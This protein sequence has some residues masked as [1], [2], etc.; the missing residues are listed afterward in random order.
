MGTR[1]C[2]RSIPP[3]AHPHSPSLS[4]HGF[5]RWVYD[6]GPCYHQPYENDAQARKPFKIKNSLCPDTRVRNAWRVAYASGVGDRASVG[7]R[8]AQGDGDAARGSGGVVG[9]LARARCSAIPSDAGSEDDRASHGR[10]PLARPVFCASYPSGSPSNVRANTSGVGR[11]DQVGK[12][13]VHESV[14]EKDVRGPSDKV[15]CVVTCDEVSDIS[16]DGSIE[17]DNRDIEAKLDEHGIDDASG[18]SGT[19]DAGDIDTST[20]SPRCGYLLLVAR[21]QASVG[22]DISL[23]MQECCKFALPGIVPA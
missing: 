7:G 19:R 17:Y 20:D 22:I 13:S 8:R 3:S 12:S 18:V 14:Q 16:S 4:F 10:A 15:L 11:E 23:T 5:S 21:V 2:H 6:V 9:W 1:H